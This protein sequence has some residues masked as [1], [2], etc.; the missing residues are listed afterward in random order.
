MSEP[1]AL[2]AGAAV[3]CAIYAASFGSI[4]YQHVVYPGFTE[5]MEGDVLQHIQRASHGDEIYPEAGTQFIPLAYFP[6]YYY[7]AAPS[8][9]LFGD[10]LAGP[11]LC[12]SL[13][14]FVA[15][16]AASR[17]AY[18][19]TGRLSPALL[20]T[21]LFFAGY[22]IK[23]ENLTTALPDAALLMWVMLG[24]S[25]L[26]GERNTFKDLAAVSFFWAAFWTKQ[27]GAILAAWGLL[28]LLFVDR[29]EGVGWRASVS[30][31]TVVALLF[32]GSLALFL[33]GLH[34]FG[35]KMFHYTVEVPGGWDR[36]LGNSLQRFVLVSFLYVPFAWL[37]FAVYALRNGWSARLLR[38][39]LNFAILTAAATC[40]YTVSASGSSNNHYIPL[41]S[42]LE[43]AVVVSAVHMAE[44]GRPRWLAG[45][46]VGTALSAGIVAVGAMWK[47][48]GH[49]IPW[50]VAAVLGAAA[51]VGFLIEYRHPWRTHWSSLLVIGQFAAS[52]YLP[53]SYCPPAGW[54]AA[55]VD[56]Q[57]EVTSLPGQVAWPEYGYVPA[58]F[59]G[60]HSERFPSWVV[61]EDLER[62]TNARPEELQHFLLMLR[63]HPPV[64]LITSTPLKDIPV[65]NHFED[66]YQLQTDYQYR[67]AALPQ[68]ASHWFGTRSYPKLLYR[69]RHNR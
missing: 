17:I 26:A 4:G 58:V 16:L 54:K 6:G 36:S 43:V 41:F 66:Q 46:L 64:W 55:V 37:A 21:A 42:L 13:A 9:W 51:I 18:L 10:G 23:D 15:A 65:W 52:A 35:P 69:L 30:V 8:L 48:E 62:S 45:V 39:P 32:G 11:R 63:K 60:T 56:L 47:N 61:L 49:I 33:T 67:F 7:L 12:S 3:V 22:R 53:W 34:P 2:V 24:W 59:T 57:A 28:Y 27:Q 14:S 1:R 40:L 38:D 19:E 25:M 20:A 68:L 44:V 50:F 31:L 5:A 29:R